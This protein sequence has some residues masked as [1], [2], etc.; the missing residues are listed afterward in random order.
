MPSH[1]VYKAAR[2]AQLSSTIYV[3][4]RRIV[5]ARLMA[6]CLLQFRTAMHSQVT[7]SDRDTLSDGA[8]VCSDQAG[9]NLV[10]QL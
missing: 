5:L 7:L 3:S 9:R 1:S 8:C 6:H 2:S 4:T 10:M